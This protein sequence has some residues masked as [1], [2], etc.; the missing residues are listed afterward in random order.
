MPN[1]ETR[2]LLLLKVVDTKKSDVDD[3]DNDDATRKVS[4]LKIVPNQNT[5]DCLYVL[6]WDQPY[7]LMS[8]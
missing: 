6:S 5:D 3:D 2:K 7:H 8:E 4:F 1:H